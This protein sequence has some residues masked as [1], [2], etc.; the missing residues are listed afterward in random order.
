MI[1]VNTS[2][3]LKTGLGPCILALCGVAALS[4]SAA[5]PMPELSWRQ[6]GYE[7]ETPMLANPLKDAKLTASGQW[8]DRGP[9][10]VVDGKVEVNN[11]WA[12]EKLP[13]TLTVEL[14]K[15]ATLGS[16]RIWFYFKDARIY[17]FFIIF[18]PFCH[19]IRT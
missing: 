16:A 10:F 4:L 17:K 18:C 5:P 15:P 6:N 11:H 7:P 3:T 12:C 9:H 13:A 2:A 8:R 19:P 1:A 14:A